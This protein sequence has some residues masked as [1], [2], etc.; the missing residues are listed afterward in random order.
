MA[1]SYVSGYFQLVVDGIDVG[2]VNSA[3]GGDAKADVAKYAMSTE[4]LVKNHLG[5][6]TYAPMKVSCGL[7]M[8]APFRD[9]IKSSLDAAHIYKN[10]EL[11][12]A[13]FNRKAVKSR[14]FKNALITGVTFPAADAKN[15][16]ATYLNV[17]FQPETTRFKKGDGSTISK[18]A[19]QKQTQFKAENFRF[20]LDGFDAVNAKVSKVDSLA[21]KQTTKWDEIGA[22]RD[23]E[24]V[25][26]KLEMPNLKIT[27]AEAVVDDLAAWHETFV[28]N[29]QNDVSQ[30]K[31]WLLEFLDQKREAVLLAIEGKGCGIFNL[32]RAEVKNNEDLVAT[33]TAEFYTD[34]ITIKEWNG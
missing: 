29:G 27:F 26:G 6:V 7:S 19:N 12:M 20:T 5:N 15:K 4:Y 3:G 21:I 34:E 18:P 11:V 8:G 23:F 9:W 31:T 13:D 33:C 14:E 25:P 22:T 2:I 32:T 30:E 17:E 16:D 10:G 24:L 1:I 28:I